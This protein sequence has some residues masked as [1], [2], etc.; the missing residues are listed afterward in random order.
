MKNLKLLNLDKNA[1]TIKGQKYGYKTAVLYLSPYTLAYRIFKQDKKAFK[2]ALKS[3]YNLNY[4]INK[5]ELA[6]KNLNSCPFARYC[7]KGCLNTSG[8]G[9][10]DMV[11]FWRAVKTAFYALDRTLFNEAIIHELKLIKKRIPENLAFRFNGTSYFW[12]AEI[13]QQALN[14]PWSIDKPRLIAFLKYF[15]AS[16]ILVCDTI[17]PLR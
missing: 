4:S 7:I 15:S 12:D 11:Q 13:I 16:F 14:L 6:L 1:K 2:K 9:R 10:Y 17:I 8:N 3:R 5:I